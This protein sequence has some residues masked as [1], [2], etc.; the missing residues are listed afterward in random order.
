MTLSEAVK[1][2]W[3]DLQEKDKIC[4]CKCINKNEPSRFK[5]WCKRAGLTSGFRLQT[6]AKRDFGAQQLDKVFF[7]IRD[8][9][10][11]RFRIKNFFCEYHPE[12]NDQFLKEVVPKNRTVC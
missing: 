5:E 8:G 11:A 10:F 1:Q 12:L 9:E 3:I 4:F 7:E 2:A 6:I